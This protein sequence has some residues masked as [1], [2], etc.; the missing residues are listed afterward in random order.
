MPQSTVVPIHS[1]GPSTTRHVT[2][3]DGRSSTTSMS[4]PPTGN[5]N[6]STPPTSPFPFVSSLPQPARPSTV[7]S[8]SYTFSGVGVLTPTRCRMSAIST[9]LD[10]VREW[11][12]L[13]VLLCSLDP[14]CDPLDSLQSRVPRRPDRRQLS[15]GAGELR[16]VHAV[17]LLPARRCRP[18]QP[19]PVE[20][21]EVLGDGLTR[22][23]QLPAQRGCGAIS[24]DEQKVEHPTAG[25]VTDGGPEIVVHRAGDRF[26]HGRTCSLATY[27]ASRGR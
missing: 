13:S 10:L 15:N 8:A 19:D 24:L 4:K 17:S 23:R 14:L 7:V 5:R 20:H 1:S 26:A 3:S 12:E 27:G 2:R 9:L 16:I 6:S 18:Y 25:R 21:D 22:D 11:P